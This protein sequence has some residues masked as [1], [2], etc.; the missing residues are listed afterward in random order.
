MHFKIKLASMVAVAVTMSAAAVSTAGSRASAQDM[1]PTLVPAAPAVIDIAP[2]DTART[3]PA[4]PQTND[5]ADAAQPA[6]LDG[7]VDAQ[8][9]ADDISSD[10]KC[11]AGAIYFEAKGET[12]AG[13]LAVARVIV[14]RSKSGR[15]PASY[16]GVVYQHSQFSFIHGR[17]MPSIREGSRSWHEALAIARIA[18]SGSFKSRSEGALYFH[19]ARVSP[20][21]RMVKIAQVDDHVF[22]R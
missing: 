3:D 9:Q 11:L 20:H 21:W 4:A 17:S 10:M 12:L 14:A 2:A 15:F 5:T 19:A 7:L 16:C 6:T 8:S 13:Q 1:I 18:D 22:Y